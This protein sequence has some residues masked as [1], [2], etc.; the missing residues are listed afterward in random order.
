MDW[1]LQITVTDAY[2]LP[3]FC[4][5]TRNI[6]LRIFVTYVSYWII[7]CSFLFIYYLWSYLL[8]LK[9]N[10]C[11]ISLNLTLAVVMVI[12][13]T[14]LPLKTRDK[15][16]F[17]SV[18]IRKVYLN[19][20]WPVL[21]YIV[22]LNGTRLICYLTI[23]RMQMKAMTR[24]LCESMLWHSL[25][26]GSEKFVLACFLNIGAVLFMMLFHWLLV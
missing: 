1:L 23:K 2:T 14:H 21:E 9:H 8:V 25:Q 5:S 19:S 20:A 26:F 10:I 18:C 12:Q 16:V 13:R 15:T 24:W 22:Y 3:Y 4:N 17:A 11:V 7:I 6:P